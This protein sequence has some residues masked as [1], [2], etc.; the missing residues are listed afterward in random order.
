VADAVPC[1]RIL[2]PV[3][4]RHTAVCGA[5]RQ[6]VGARASV[7]VGVGSVGGALVERQCARQATGHAARNT[8]RPGQPARAD[9]TKGLRPW[10]WPLRQWY[11]EG[12]V[13]VFRSAGIIRSLKVHIWTRPRCQGAREWNNT[14]RDRC[15]HISGLLVKTFHSLRALMKS[16][17]PRLITTAA[18]RALYLRRVGGSRSDRSC[19]QLV[20]TSHCAEGLLDLS[21]KSK[22][23]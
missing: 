22:S 15:S 5:A 8:A 23:G 10:W 9:K 13:P 14:L 21:V 12:I 18:S 6:R 19:P 20:H 7:S 11:H 4:R 1:D 17:L 3:H 2:R 16:A